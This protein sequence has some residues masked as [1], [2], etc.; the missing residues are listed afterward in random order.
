MCNLIDDGVVDPWA[1]TKSALRNAS[2]VTG[3]IMSAH[4]VVTP[5]TEVPYAEVVTPNIP[6]L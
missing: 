1:V 5:S 3:R 4:A 6:S 2:S